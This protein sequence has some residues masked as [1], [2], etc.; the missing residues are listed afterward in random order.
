[1]QPGNSCIITKILNVAINVSSNSPLHRSTSFPNPRRAQVTWTYGI[2][3]PCVSSPRI[4]YLH[5]WEWTIL[6]YYIWR[7]TPIVMIKQCLC[8]IFPSQRPWLRLGLWPSDTVGS[9]PTFEHRSW[10]SL[11]CIIVYNQGRLNPGY[12]LLF[13]F[14]HSLYI[15]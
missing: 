14:C 10:Q 2:L 13:Q 5:T 12:A 9:W 1:M 11:V 3:F 6:F 4:E 8:C 15:T 7:Q